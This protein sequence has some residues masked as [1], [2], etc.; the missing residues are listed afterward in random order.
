MLA[1]AAVCALAACG[2]S[3]QPR[4]RRRAVDGGG[5]GSSRERLNRVSAAGTL[6]VID[7]GG[8]YDRGLSGGGTL[9]IDVRATDDRWNTVTAS[10]SV[11]VVR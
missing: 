7:V 2:G 11:P 1:I 6:D 5:R 9:T 3:L 10:L 8:H 4:R